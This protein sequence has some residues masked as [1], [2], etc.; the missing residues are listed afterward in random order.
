MSKKIRTTVDVDALTALTK[1]RSISMDAIASLVKAVPAL[2]NCIN[3]PV[4]VREM[5][6]NKH[7][8]IDAVTG[9][10]ILDERRFGNWA[11]RS[12][13]L[14]K[15][16]FDFEIVTDSLGESVLVVRRKV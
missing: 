12:L 6:H 11:G 4:T 8:L 16:A 10:S 14:N 15:A 1:D 5:T 9:I 3:A 2:R 13:Y 7:M